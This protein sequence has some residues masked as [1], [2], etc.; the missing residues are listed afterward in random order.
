MKRERMEFDVVIVGAGP[1]GL[2]AAIRLKQLQPATQVCVLEK[3][4]SIGSHIVSGAIVETRA[5]DELLPEWRDSNCPLS[6]PVAHSRTLLLRSASKSITVAEWLLPNSL[7]HNQGFKRNRSSLQQTYV[8][9][10]SNLC[11]WLAEQAE[12][13][14][15]EIYT[16]FCASEVIFESDGSVAGVL[17]GDMGRAKDG[18]EKNNFMPG[19]ELQA[20]HTVFAEGSRGHLGKQ[21][22]SHFDLAYSKDPQH[23]AL[24]IKELWQVP[25]HSYQPG[26]VIHTTGWPLSEH[27]TH[28]GGFLYHL[29]NQRVAVGLVTDLS[30]SNPWLSPF[31]EFQRF[32][33][34]PQIA[35][36]LKTGERIGYG[37]KAIT[38]GGLQ[39]LP[40]MDFPGGMLI[41]D[42][43]GT[44]N[45][46]KLKGVHT[47][48]KSGM[49]AAEVIAK[50][51]STPTTQA[52]PRKMGDSLTTRYRSSWACEELKIHRNF[53]PAQQRWGNFWGSG[54]ALVDINLFKGT[55]PW[56]LKS[57][58][59]DYLALHTLK[60]APPIKYSKPDGHLSFDHMS[61]VYL[62][63]IYHPDDQ[64]CHLKLNDLSITQN[65][66]IP[67]Y[68]EPA[69]RYCPAAVY[70]VVANVVTNSASNTTSGNASQ[71]TT[72]ATQEA[73]AA[74]QNTIVALRIDSANC[75]HCKTCD[76]KDPAQNIIWTPPEGGSGPN[77]SGL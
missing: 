75:L 57:P 37:A 13:L 53:A 42:D 31:N 35:H 40:V 23:F 50:T 39:S 12:S 14:G 64:P 26:L 24:G 27:E 3:G 55:L 73:K 60:T 61:S 21:L 59:A 43:A 69:Q 51:V 47:A 65:H 2:T 38:K 49:E 33:Q 54:Y 66:T 48:M 71:E 67:L 19:I 29:D 62:S 52:S 68:D 74:S 63:N 34:H 76:I 7:R 1:A 18:S 20:R 41:G 56:T 4:A 17:T 44:L 25:E 9:S 36:F 58:I 70:E 15:V 72:A 32:K 30:Y 22:I 77:Y 11:I 16:G 46:G 5:L 8:T 28:G 45:P 10:L 6:T